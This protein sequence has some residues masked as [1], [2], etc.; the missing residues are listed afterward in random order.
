MKLFKNI[1]IK[2]KLTAKELLKIKSNIRKLF[3]AKSYLNDS[4][5]EFSNIRKLMKENKTLDDI[6][7]MVVNEEIE[8]SNM[9]KHFSARVYYLNKEI[10]KITKNIIAQQKDMI[11]IFKI[12]EFGN[13][14]MKIEEDYKDELEKAI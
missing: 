6:I 1:S 13:P 3:V 14:N 8:V 5:N 9:F 12:N 11:K 7:E 4:K 10:E 2:E